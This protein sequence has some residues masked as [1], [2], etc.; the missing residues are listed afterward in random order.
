MFPVE[1]LPLRAPARVYWNENQIP[2]IEAEDDRDLPMLLGMVHAH[3]RLGQMEV[4][5]RVSQGRLAEM[6]GPVAGFVDASLRIVNH[7]KVARENW[8]RMRPDTKAWLE[9]FV[10][11]IN[12]YRQRVERRP[13]E[14]AALGFG[15]EEWTPIDVLTIGRLGGTDINWGLYLSMLSRRGEAKWP[16]LYERL[17]A[18]GLGAAP[19]FGG[20]DPLKLAEGVSKS[21]SN[22]FAVSGAR[23]GTGAGLIA[24]DPHVGLGLPNLWLVVGIKSPAR[25]AV[26]MMLPGVPAVLLGRNERIAFGGTN[27]RSLNTAMYDASKVPPEQ[28]TTRTSVIKQRWWLDREQAVRE[29]PLGPIITDAPIFSAART[30]GP[31]I[32]MK[33]RGHEPSDELTAFMD[34]SVAR[35]FDEFRRAFEPFAVSGQNFLYADVEGNIGQVL[36]L[37]FDAAAG[38]AALVGVADPAAPGMQWGQE[39]YRSTQLP[40][41]YNP[42]A[43][44]LVSSNNN[45]VRTEPPITIVANADDRYLRISELI[46]SAGSL[47]KPEAL[48]IQ[49]DVYSRSSHAVARAMAQRAPELTG[50]AR[51]ARDVIAAWDGRYEVESEGAPMFQAAFYH[52]IRAH[53]GASYG[54]NLSEY[55]LNSEAVYSLMIEEFEAGR[56]DGSLAQALERAAKDVA[57]GTTWG[58]RHKLRVAHYIGNVPVLG[59]AWRF[60]EFGVRGSLKTVF[61]TANDVSR[62][63]HRATYGANSRHISDLADLDENYFVLLGGQDGWLGSV[64]MLDQVAMWR[65]GDMVRV[66]MRIQ[67]VRSWA[68]RVTELAPGEPAL[69]AGDSWEKQWQE[70]RR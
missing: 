12:L 49:M 69:P 52:L 59:A 7:G 38:R 41:A 28:I 36:A 44:Y 15:E 55:L 56:V 9:R 25:H 64:N 11:G 4:L 27:M 29:T 17:K 50:G 26:G 6:A 22:S 66:P 35:N 8:E 10:A 42:A 20:L 48:R 65:D 62:G 33:W 23:T 16:E 63:V 57:T 47:R 70:T 68:K 61:K 2:F 1:R 30:N 32:A 53:F 5:K 60:E 31:E 34:M 13:A 67:S 40:H 37:E 14:F 21:G 51:R 58:D 39:R 46:E 54:E 24:N 43:G 18:Y 19:S 45:P 3:Q